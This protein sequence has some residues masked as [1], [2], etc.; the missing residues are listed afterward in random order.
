MVISGLSAKELFERG[1]GVTYNDFNILNTR[2]SEITREDISLEVNLGK[3]ITLKTPIIA[4]PMDTVTNGR[5]CIALALQGGI[6]V[7]HYNHKDEDGKPSID[8]QVREIEAVK[9]FQNG[10][11]DSPVTINP[12]MTIAQAI[13]L[14]KSRPIG[15]SYIKTFPVTEKGETHGKLVGFLTKGD[16]REGFRNDDKVSARMIS[17]DKLVFGKLPITLSDAYDRM[18]DNHVR[19]L[20]IVDQQGN[21]KYLVTSADVGKLDK[22]PLSTK[23][24]NNKL[25]VLFSVSTWPKDAYERLERGFDAGADGVVV[26]TSQGYN[27]HSKEMIEYIKKKYSE[28]FLI[29]GN[30]STS[31]ATVDLSE[32]G[33]NSFRD[34]QGA[35]SICTTAGAL[36]IA[37]AGATAVYECALTLRDE[38]RKDVIVI[39][40]GGIKEAGDITK[41]LFIGARVVMLGNLLAGSEESPGEIIT[42]SVSGMPVKIYRG[43]GSAEANVRGGLRGYRKMPQGISDTVRYRGSIHEWVPLLR[44]AILQAFEVSNYR[45]IQ[46]AHQGTYD[47]KTRF[48]R[49]TLGSIQEMG[50]HSLMGSGGR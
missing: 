25:R 4:S 37:R 10:F 28:R 17:L 50:T 38:N 24:A 12:E 22:Y 32:W 40:D 41:A 49:R 48:E 14:G 18:Y 31:E 13:E 2:F 27:I 35:G 29:G 21:L 11:I 42:D 43:M 33:V 9:K 30:I 44:D 46:E 36:G 6:G 3:G 19:S 34:G 39:A 8:Q 23:D 5:V 45:S 20:P 47:G 16:Y 1:L 7:I 26:D 15:N